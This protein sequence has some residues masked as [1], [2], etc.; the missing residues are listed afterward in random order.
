MRATPLLYGKQKPRKEKDMV[1]Y[2]KSKIEAENSP[3][4]RLKSSDGREVVF[5]LRIP[6]HRRKR[7][8]PLRI[9]DR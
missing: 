3:G 4:G 1:Q 8:F 7:V 5:P 9:Q 2:K 6:P